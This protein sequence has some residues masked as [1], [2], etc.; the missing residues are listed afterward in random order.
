MKRPSARPD[1][2][3]QILRRGV[4]PAV[5]GVDVHS[6]QGKQQKLP[7]EQTQQGANG[8]NPQ[9]DEHRRPHRL[10][11]GDPRDVARPVVV[12]DVLLDGVSNQRRGLRAVPVLGPVNDAGNEIHKEVDADGLGEDRPPRPFGTSKT[13]SKNME[14][15]IAV[16]GISRVP[17]RPLKERFR[18]IISI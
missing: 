4:R 11:E 16:E 9:R 15:S 8:K 2:P 1:H 5:H 6:E 7:T 12:E 14:S 17:N 13:G 3:V 18:E 10:P